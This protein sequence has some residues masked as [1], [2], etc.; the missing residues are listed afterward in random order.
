MPNQNKKTKKTPKIMQLQF[1]NKHFHVEKLDFLTYRLF[2]EAGSCLSFF[3]INLETKPMSNTA[4][5]DLY[6]TIIDEVILESRQDFENAGIDE[7]T[8]QDL[9]DIWRQRLL[10]AKVANFSWAPQEDSDDNEGNRGELGFTEGEDVKV[11]VEENENHLLE[12]SQ[13]STLPPPT[14]QQQQQQPATIDTGLLMSSHGTDV[15][16]S[17]RNNQL[18]DGLTFTK[19]KVEKKQNRDDIGDDSDD[20]D[21]LGSDLGADSDAINSDLDDSDDEDDEDGD[22]GGDDDDSGNDIEQN[23]MLCLYDRVQRVRNRWKCSLKDGLMNINGKD[24][25]FQKAN[26]DSEW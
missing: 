20:D 18:E 11:K 13:Q 4:C 9:R 24:Y 21:D 26:G 14:Q 2:S 19:T 16:F 10:A 22:N 23:I 3:C 5:A 12:Q 15:T 17:I 6:T 8:L 1:E 7:Q 25:V